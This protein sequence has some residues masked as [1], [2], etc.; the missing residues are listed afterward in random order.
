MACI[1]NAKGLKIIA[2]CLMPLLE[3]IFA[4]NETQQ[5][6]EASKRY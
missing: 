1:Q 3:D 5:A 4:V 6:T 2:D